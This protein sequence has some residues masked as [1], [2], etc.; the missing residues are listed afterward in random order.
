[1]EKD[2]VFRFSY[3]RNSCIAVLQ[4]INYWSI[5]VTRL[6]TE[7]GLAQGS[8]SGLHASRGQSSRRSGTPLIVS[9]IQCIQQ[10]NFD[11]N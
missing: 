10:I 5:N 4:V 1:M 8:I 7:S 2:L 3:C 11:K 6:R 9:Y